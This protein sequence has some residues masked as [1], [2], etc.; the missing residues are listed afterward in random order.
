MP[1]MTPIIEQFDRYLLEKK[2][3]FQAVIIGGGALNLLNITSRA[4]V[5]IDFLDPI[6]PADI[7]KA[8]ISF[9]KE[10]ETL[11]LNA[12]EWFNNGPLNLVRDLPKD[13][14]ARTQIIY[15]GSNLKL[16]TLG[17]LDLLKTKLYAYCDRVK[18]LDD[19]VAM[20]PTLDELD[21]CKK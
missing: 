17:R 14:R 2:L 9:A 13:W 3:F 19:C 15:N 21:S 18:D 7:K 6:I 20:R 8:S 4:T 1:F 11:G 16:Y 5:D 10:N 12:E